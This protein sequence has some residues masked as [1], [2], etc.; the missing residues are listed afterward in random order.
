MFFK[1]FGVFSF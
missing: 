1:I